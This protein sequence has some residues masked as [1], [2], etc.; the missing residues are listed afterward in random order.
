MADWQDHA[1]SVC[2]KAFP[3]YQALGGHKATRHRTKPSAPAPVTDLGD[4]KEQQKHQP[5][6]RGR[7]RRRLLPPLRRRPLGQVEET[8]DS[9]DVLLAATGGRGRIVASWAEVGERRA[10][11]GEDASHARVSVAI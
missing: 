4:N 10:E 8:D 9:A 5:R 1:G 2:G 6:R 7:G 3:L 11:V